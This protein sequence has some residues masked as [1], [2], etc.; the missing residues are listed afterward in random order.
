MNGCN[1]GLVRER[2]SALV[3]GN[4]LRLESGIIIRRHPLGVQC[5]NAFCTRQILD[6]KD[7]PFCGLLCE[8]PKIRELVEDKMGDLD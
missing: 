4:S 6:S 7:G 8:N 3:N 2:A 5:N 1:V